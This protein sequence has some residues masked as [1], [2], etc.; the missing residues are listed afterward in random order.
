MRSLPLETA[1]GLMSCCAPIEVDLNRLIAYLLNIPS[2]YAGAEQ[3][4]GTTCACTKRRI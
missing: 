4:Q 2:C 1:R 3:V